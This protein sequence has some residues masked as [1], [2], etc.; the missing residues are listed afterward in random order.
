MQS[1]QVV[2][3]QIGTVRQGLDLV[4]ITSLGEGDWQENALTCGAKLQRV[5]HGTEVS[6]NQ[7]RIS[8]SSS[9]EQGRYPPMLVLSVIT[10]TAYGKGGGP[11][12]VFK[13]KKLSKV[14]AYGLDDPASII[15]TV[16]TASVVRWLRSEPKGVN[17]DGQEMISKQ[18]A[19]SW[20]EGRVAGT[21]AEPTLGHVNG[22]EREEPRSLAD[23]Y[24][25]HADCGGQSE[26]TRDVGLV[27]I[28]DPAGLCLAASRTISLDVLEVVDV[29]IGWRSLDKP[30][31]ELDVPMWEAPWKSKSV[32]KSCDWEDIE[33]RKALEGHV[34]HWT[35]SGLCLSLEGVTVQRETTLLA[36][37]EQQEG[38]EVELRDA[39]NNLRLT[40]AVEG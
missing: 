34:L 32:E 13:D 31:V 37:D 26:C 29:G 24:E 36:G 23:R 5:L 28:A 19:E 12:F 1:L 11:V 4:R 25:V 17:G 16:A 8:P 9:S 21:L 22:R 20:G 35:P 18:I 3:G 27:G 40:L 39:S 15:H 33:D 10:V 2:T 38:A 6:M 7:I 30:L 14:D